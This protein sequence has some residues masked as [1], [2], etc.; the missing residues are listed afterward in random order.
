MN[1]TTTSAPIF[2]KQATPAVLRLTL[3]KNW[4]EMIASGEKKEDYRELKD[5]WFDR[6]TEND[7]P[8]RA[9]H[10]DF[11]EFKNGYAKSAP[12]LIVECKGIMI[13]DAK[14]EWSD[15]WQGGCFIISLGK[16]VSSTA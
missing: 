3:K 13:G 4:F 9:K 12:T 8:L 1:N 2:A 6:L 11:V 10:F 14:P 5:Y 15:N 16:V 7:Y